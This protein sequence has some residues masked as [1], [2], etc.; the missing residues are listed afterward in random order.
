MRCVATDPERIPL[1]AP[2]ELREEALRFLMRSIGTEEM[3]HKP[4]VML[5]SKAPKDTKDPVAPVFL[6][7]GIEGKLRPTSYWR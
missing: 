5:P 7:P 1:T 3:G 4:I 6:I 2:S